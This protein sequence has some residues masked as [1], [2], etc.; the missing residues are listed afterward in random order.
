M[1]ILLVED[2]RMVGSAV[3]QNL[4]DT[5]HA[6]DWVR[7]GS[8]ALEAM[9]VQ[10][11]MAVLLDLGLPDGNGFEILKKLRGRG[12]ATPVLI[13]TAWDAVEDR[14]RGLDLGADDYMVKPFAMPELLARLRAVTRRRSGTTACV[15]GNGRL[16]LDLTTHEL[17]ASGVLATLSAREFSLL[18]ALLL[19]PGAILSRGQLEDAIYGWGEEV[20]SNAVEAII[21][22]IRRKFG[23]KTIK[24]VRG[25]GWKVDKQAD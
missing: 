23:A 16:N 21:Y 25:V 10:R 6:V 15:L 3:A 7:D 24:N 5:A 18:E 9:A 13:L 2:D 11:Y 20:E 22:S 14:V 12:D 8:S 1:R 17:T 19:R 4:K